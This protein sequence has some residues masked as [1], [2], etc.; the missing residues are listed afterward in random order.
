M[1]INDQRGSTFLKWAA[2]RVHTGYRQ[3]D[4][5]HDAC[6]ATLLGFLFWMDVGFRH[7]YSC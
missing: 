7:N 5:L 2:E 1:A 3:W 4:R 6:A